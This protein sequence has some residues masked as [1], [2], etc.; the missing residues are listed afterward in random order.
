MTKSMEEINYGPFD[1]D[2]KEV[3]RYV[4][5]GHILAKPF[6][7]T[8]ADSSGLGIKLI[9]SFDEIKR[10][11]YSTDDSVR[12]YEP[13]IKRADWEGILRKDTEK[14]MFDGYL[15]E[16]EN[17][18]K[19]GAKFNQLH[20][21]ISRSLKNHLSEILPAAEIENLVDYFEMLCECRV[22]FG[23]KS[24]L[25]HETLFPIFLAGG[26]P[27]GWQGAY[28]RGQVVVYLPAT[29]LTNR[30]QKTM[31]LE[32]DPIEESSGIQEG[33]VDSTH[34]V[35]DSVQQKPLQGVSS[36]DGEYAY[37]LFDAPVEEVS[38]Y[39]AEYFEKESHALLG[40]IAGE[41]VELPAHFLI[42][43]ELKGTE[44]TYVVSSPEKN[45]LL[46]IMEDFTQ[47]YELDGFYYA[48][49]G[50]EKSLLFHH[51]DVDGYSD[52][53][54]EYVLHDANKIQFFSELR[55]TEVPLTADH[56]L[57]IINDCFEY[58]EIDD[59]MLNRDALLTGPDADGLF[60]LNL[61]KNPGLKYEI[62]L[63]NLD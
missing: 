46:P 9:H 44:K 59:L 23:R 6:S 20:T 34:A 7:Q 35:S 22:S 51:Y 61:K 4:L 45:E 24:S 15:S 52:E 62:D 12:E 26:Y 56:L 8:I 47:T 36:I 32:S 27:C 3:I 53:K 17:S 30:T 28:P 63:L 21:D 16:G 1:S 25:V 57:E 40:D 14:M 10:Y 54:V 49:S 19:F 13:Y 39:L 60:T 43:I 38:D 33:D 29:E 55:E 42:L 48:V 2:V 11:R 37:A 58:H 41:P 50:K 31:K 5:S 18:L